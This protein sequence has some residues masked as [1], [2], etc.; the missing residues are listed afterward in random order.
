LGL[1]KKCKKEG[2]EKFYTDTV[3]VY[4]YVEVDDGYGGTV[5]ELML[6][7]RDNRCRLSQKTISVTSGNPLA[8][9]TQ[10]FRLFI[11]L[12]T[13]IAQND[14]LEVHRGS[15][16]YTFKAGEPFAYYD[17]TPHKEIVVK[18]VVENGRNAGMAEK[19]RNTEE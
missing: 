3:D 19:T 8:V 16:I 5:E 15:M 10:E 6:I 18:E 9:S 13:D 11:S 1:L 7:S 2:I 12:E 14:K 4:R 17:R